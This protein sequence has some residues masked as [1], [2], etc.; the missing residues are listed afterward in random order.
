M[1]ILDDAGH[2]QSDLLLSVQLK[3]LLLLF[4][5]Q[6]A[7]KF[8]HIVYCRQHQFCFVFNHYLFLYMHALVSL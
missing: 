8:A 1:L 7:F 6:T 2:F 5:V 3:P 4:F